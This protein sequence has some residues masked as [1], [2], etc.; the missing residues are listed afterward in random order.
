MRLLMAL[1]ISA[2]A[3]GADR[4]HSD[5]REIIGGRASDSLEFPTVLYVA[6]CTGSLIADRWALTAAH[7]VAGKGCTTSF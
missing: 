4:N 1:I 7:C 6:G 5:P 2:V 3:F